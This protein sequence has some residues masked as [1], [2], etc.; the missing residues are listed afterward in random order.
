MFG[1]VKDRKSPTFNLSLC[2]SVKRKVAQVNAKIILHQDPNLPSQRVLV[3]NAGA[4]KIYNGTTSL[5]CFEKK[6]FSSTLKNALDYH[7]ASGAVENAA[8]VGLAPGRW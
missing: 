6:Y 4:V 1:R 8:V 3:D 2:K 5:V 7:D